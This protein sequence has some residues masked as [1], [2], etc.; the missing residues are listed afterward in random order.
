MGLR[1]R[2]MTHEEKIKVLRSGKFTLYFHDNDESA[3]SVYDTFVPDDVEDWDDFD[4]KHKLFEGTGFGG[5]GYCP[6]VIVLL[7]E[8]LGGK[9]DSI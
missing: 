7:V 5:I 8:A 2:I 3:W 1:N 6:E 4:R 9:V